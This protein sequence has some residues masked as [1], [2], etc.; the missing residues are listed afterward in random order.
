LLNDPVHET[1]IA[2]TRMPEMFVADTIASALAKDLA[3]ILEIRHVLTERADGLLLVWIAVDDPSP[4][5]RGR[6]YQKELD[7]ISRFPEVDFDFNVVPAMGRSAD[8]IAGGAS[9]VYSR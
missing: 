9:V 4:R 2:R 3:S 7:L 8:Q 1:M 5:V 6:V